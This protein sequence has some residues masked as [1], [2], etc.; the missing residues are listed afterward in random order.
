MS[1]ETLLLLQDAHVHYGGVKA[2]DG[3]SITL[4]EGEIIALMGPNGA[5]KSTVLKALFGLA[6]LTSGEVKWEGTVIRPI[7]HQVVRRGISFVPQGRRVFADLTVEENLEI[8]GYTVGDARLVRERMNDLFEMFP[9]LRQK[10]HA[11]S[12]TLSGGQQQMLAI[13]RGLMTDPKVLLLD[14]PS[15]GLAPKVV[16]EVF[17]FVKEINEKRNMA[18]VVVE[19]NI[20]SLLEI[21]TRGY[22]LDKGRVVAE[23]SPQELVAAGTLE[24]VFTGVAL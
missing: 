19:H 18:V 6:P 10:R 14:E 5:G 20:K 22:V 15:L 16:K 21:A 9:M 4:D 2:L 23:G 12:G 13:A 11:K 3:A 24:K 7:P 8:G 17:A 1:T